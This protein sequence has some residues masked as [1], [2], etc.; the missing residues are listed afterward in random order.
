MLYDGSYLNRFINQII[1]PILPES[2]VMHG[3]GPGT[4]SYLY[5]KASSNSYI[6][7]LTNQRVDLVSTIC[8]DK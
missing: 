6:S 5:I 1:Y 8:H 4:I 3:D 2:V 7:P